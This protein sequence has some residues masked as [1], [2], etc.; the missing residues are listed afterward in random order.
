MIVT[1]Y[2]GTISGCGGSPEG[3]RVTGSV[4]LNGDPLSE[5]TIVFRPM[6]RA[7]GQ[8]IE[9]KVL[10]GKFDVRQESGV[11][12]RHRVEIYAH[13]SVAQREPATQDPLPPGQQPPSGGIQVLPDQFNRFSTLA[14]DILPGENRADFELMGQLR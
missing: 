14:F 2:V 6:A 8:S 11:F 3:A 10:D 9:G 13:R 4:T 12:G 7:T 1:L 5:A